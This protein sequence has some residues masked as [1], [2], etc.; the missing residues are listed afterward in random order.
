MI[1]IIIITIIAIMIIIIN[2]GLFHCLWA[3]LYL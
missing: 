2:T 3:R 1:I